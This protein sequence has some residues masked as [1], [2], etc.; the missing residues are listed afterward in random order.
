MATDKLDASGVSSD[1]GLP[2]AVSL[3][4]GMATDKLDPSGVSPGESVVAVG[5]AV[6]F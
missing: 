4:L 1:G 6:I 2:S 3:V 5:L